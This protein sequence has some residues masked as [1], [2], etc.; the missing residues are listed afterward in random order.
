MRAMRRSSAEMVVVLR[1][2]NAF[3]ASLLSGN[4]RCAALLIYLRCP[5]AES[6]GGIP[7]SVSASLI[8]GRVA[9]VLGGAVPRLALW[10][11]RAALRVED[12]YRIVAL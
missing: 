7:S 6:C 5:H 2:L 8:L 3:N 4:G 9:R 11:I 10:L 1:C 12:A